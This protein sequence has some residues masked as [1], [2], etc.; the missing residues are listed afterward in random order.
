MVV[1]LVWELFTHLPLLV[2]LQVTTSENQNELA[3][4]KFKSYYSN[5]QNTKLCMRVIL[6][7]II[8]ELCFKPVIILAIY[9]LV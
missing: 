5:N 8:I 3:A 7:L 9:N 2:H 6:F 4:Y 1:H